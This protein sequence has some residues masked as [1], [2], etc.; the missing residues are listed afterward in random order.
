MF[1]M[2]RRIYALFNF[3]LM[4]LNQHLIQ[5]LENGTAARGGT[6]HEQMTRSLVNFIHFILPGR[7]RRELEVE[8][9]LDQAEREIDA[10]EAQIENYTQTLNRWKIN[11]QGAVPLPPPSMSDE[12]Q[13]RC[14][15]L[16]RSLNNPE[17][18][19][20]IKVSTEFK[21]NPD[22]Y[23]N[24]YFNSTPHF[25]RF[26]LERIKD[27][28]GDVSKEKLAFFMM[29]PRLKSLPLD[30]V[31]EIVLAANNLE[32]QVLPSSL[33][34]EVQKLDLNYYFE[35]LSNEQ[36]K[37]IF[38]RSFDAEEYMSLLLDLTRSKLKLEPANQ[39]RDLIDY[40]PVQEEKR[41]ERIKH[42]YLL[43][44]EKIH[45]PGLRIKLLATKKDFDQASVDFSNCVRTYHSKPQ[46][47]VFTVYQNDKEPLACVE[48]MHNKILQLKG[49]RNE[50][51]SLVIRTLVEDL[52]NHAR[53]A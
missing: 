14:F 7:Y 47:D 23:L 17:A 38:T 48:I 50:T 18:H 19:P 30:A 39:M 24:T 12:V 3:E 13:R 1:D 20:V 34:K 15:E 10:E 32:Y 5:E 29:I 27:A 46:S 28:E 8:N 49:V 51:P 9:F 2:F 37:M 22:L 42:K 25:K 4:K 43:N 44:L 6:Q 21:V 40:A 16:Y 52:L 33:F 31:R 53:R 36:I 45:R 26:F 41:Q 11:Y 35:K